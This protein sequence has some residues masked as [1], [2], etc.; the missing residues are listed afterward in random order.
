MWNSFRRWRVSAAAGVCAAILVAGLCV[1][2]HLN[3][4]R[5]I[6]RANLE[7]KSGV[8]FVRG[9]SEPFSGFLVEHYD[10]GAK[11]IEIVIRRGV[12]DGLSRG[13]FENG[14]LEVEEH[15]VHGISDG[16]RTRWHANGQRR[17]TGLIVQGKFSGL[18]EEWHPNGRKAIE[19]TF[20]NGKPDGLA[21]R[22]PRARENRA[23]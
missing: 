2:L 21:R 23:S 5:S 20:R 17:S 9:E 13:W 22:V 19:I 16:R 10:K 12:V 11:K 8:L 14:Q 7:L 1:W 4:P 15:F 18:Y 3:K 6:E